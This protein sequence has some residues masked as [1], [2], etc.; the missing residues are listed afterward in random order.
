MVLWQDASYS[1]DQGAAS[2]PLRRSLSASGEEIDV[3]EE[4]K[5]E[6]LALFVKHRLV[7]AIKDQVEAVREGLSV[8]ITED[9]RETLLQCCTVA[10]IQLLICG[11]P[12]I[13]IGDWKAAA[14]YRG[15]SATS[16]VV[17]WFW[18][19]VRS[20]SAEQRAQLLHFCTG[21]SRAPA[22]G[23]ASL[24]ALPACFPS[25]SGNHL[26]QVVLARMGYAGAQH[27]F[28]IMEDDDDDSR[29]PSA[30]T[31]FVRVTL[32]RFVARVCLLLIRCHHAPRT[33]SACPITAANRRCRRD[34]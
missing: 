17:L 31:C 15:Y 12:T 3:T 22:A 11:V 20:S 26:I 16:R 9:L 19:F 25:C 10:D 4:N 8:F 23:F 32:S 14:K 34:F 1:E 5:A 7:G 29:L 33:R 30:A 27:E 21:S 24:C 28:T 2:I 13:D 6:Y 18:K